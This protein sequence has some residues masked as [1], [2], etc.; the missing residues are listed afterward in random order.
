M[1][2]IDAVVDDG[3]LHTVAARAR[4]RREC[5]R[6]EHGRPAVQVEVYVRLG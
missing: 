2:L 3:D 6:S 4:R 1:L 5:R